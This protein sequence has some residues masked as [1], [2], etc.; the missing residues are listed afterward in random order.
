M[1]SGFASINFNNS[2]PTT[3][4][5]YYLNE[6]PIEEANPLDWL[7]SYTLCDIIKNIT[8]IDIPWDYS[9]KDEDN[10]NNDKIN[11]ILKNWGMD[12]KETVFRPYLCTNN[13]VLRALGLCDK[14]ITNLLVPYNP[15]SSWK[16]DN[17]A[18]KYY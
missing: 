7:K 1:R 8:P 4:T 12:P 10:L 17:N 14:K 15:K 16:L 5:I 9:K 18:C 6:G 3:K 13:N 11:T 2:L